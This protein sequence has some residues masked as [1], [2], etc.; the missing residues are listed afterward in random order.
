MGSDQEDG[1]LPKTMPF[2][3]QASKRKKSSLV[4]GFNEGS[5]KDFITGFRKR[6]QQ[7]RKQAQHEI[8]H[9]LKKAKIEARKEKKA[10][11]QGQYSGSAGDSHIITSEQDQEEE[12]AEYDNQEVTVKV[13]SAPV[14]ASAASAELDAPQP[15]NE[16]VAADDTQ[17][18]SSRKQKGKKY[19]PGKAKVWNK[20]V[21]RKQRRK[22]KR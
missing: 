5:R 9:R 1:A 12:E 17:P 16:P 22:N 14:A 11:L 2:G 4:I 18:F 7:R 6:K 20:N 8:D 3:P 13:T 15:S 19:R 21:A 10:L